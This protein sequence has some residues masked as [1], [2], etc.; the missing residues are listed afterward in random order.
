MAPPKSYILHPTSY[1][2]HRAGFTLVE[3]LVTISVILTLAGMTLMAL[4]NVRQSARVT[5]TKT[6]ITKLDHIIQQRYE[7]YLTRRVPVDMSGLTPK[8]AAENRYRARLYMLMM[9]MPDR[10]NNLNISGTASIP[11]PYGNKQLAWS[12][13]ARQYQARY[14]AKQ[15]STDYIHAEMLYMVV[16]SDP[17]NRQLF[18]DDEIA[19]VDRDGWPEFIDG[20]GMPIYWLRCAPGLHQIGLSMVQHADAVNAHDPFDPQKVQA[21]AYHLV[22]F[23]YS[24]GPD[25]KYGINVGQKV[26]FN[27]N[28]FANLEI[29]T[30][31][32]A[33]PGA[34][35]DNVHNHF[36]DQAP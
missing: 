19:D 33:E 26:Q 17:E 30:E 7:S 35:A 9:D 24:A 13:L 36:I 10:L 2:L 22:P 4:S 5:K 20:W 23:I 27:G 31:D 34:T 32:P 3:L 28:A 18:A 11:L 12:A 16:M 15:P 29:G 6:T 14:N 1:I 8:Q 21:D 25:K